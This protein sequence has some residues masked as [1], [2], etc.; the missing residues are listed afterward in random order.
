MFGKGPLFLIHSYGIVGGL[1]DVGTE[2]K[3][4]SADI[5]FKRNLL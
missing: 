3:R 2:E 5:Q 4:E 1:C